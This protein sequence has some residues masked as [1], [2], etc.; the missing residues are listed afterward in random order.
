MLFAL[1]K[2]KAE[3]EY[4]VPHTENVESIIEDGLKIGKSSILDEEDEEE[5][6]EG[7]Y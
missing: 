3:L 6:G 4:D 7:D 5:D 1:K 2:Y